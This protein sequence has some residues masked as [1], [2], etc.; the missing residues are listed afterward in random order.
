MDPEV[1]ARLLGLKLH[2]LVREHFGDMEPDA[3][4][5]LSVGAASCHGDT[6]WVLVEERTDRGLGVALAWAS[7]RA[8]TTV[9]ILAND[10]TGTLA[11]RATHFAADVRVWKVD[12]IAIAAAHLDEFEPEPDASPEHLA[13]VP[14]ILDSGA[15]VVIEHGVVAGEVEGLEV[16]RVVID[17]VTGANRLEV[18]VGEH[19]REAFA[20]LHGDTPTTDSLKR[21]VEVVKR[22]REIDADPH[23]LNRLGA[24]R[25]LRARVIA[26]PSLIGARDLRTVASPT[27]RPNLKDPVPCVAVGSTTE[28]TAL[29]AVFSTGIDL[30]VVPFAADARAFH[31]P[32][33]G[34]AADLVI[35]V[36]R[37]DVSAV[38]TRVAEL[39]HRPAR[40]VGL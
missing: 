11:R 36:P 26:N 10:H 3:Q 37:R 2:A 4:A 39:L 32:T 24:E 33:V 9:H 28:G 27:P 20:M 25:A 38:T 5:G 17:P 29:V 30:D 34:D 14:T 8:V 6:A 12:G 7:K 40:I 35:V 18:G 19:D 21:I 1:R 23:P 15:E 31:A 13:F 16:C 22:H